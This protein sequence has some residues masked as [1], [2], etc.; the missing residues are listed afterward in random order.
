MKFKIGDKVVLSTKGKRKIDRYYLP[1][2]KTEPVYIY[3]CE[4]DSVVVITEESETKFAL[5]KDFLKKEC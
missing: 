1:Y 5:S 3:H 4:S 2:F